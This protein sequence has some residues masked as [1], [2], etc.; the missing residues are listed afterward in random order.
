MDFKLKY[1]KN[2]KALQSKDLKVRSSN[3][4]AREIDTFCRLLRLANLNESFRWK[5][6]TFLDLGAGDQFLKP[7][8]TEL[9]A[10]YHP[11]DYDLA[12]FNKDELPY[13][14]NS[15]DLIFSLAVI[16]HI[17]NIDHFLGQVYRL[18]KPGGIFYLSTP[19]FKYCYKSFYNDP[20]HVRPFTEVSIYKVLSIFGFENI[21]T[22]PGLRSKSDWFYTNRFRFFISA[23]LL[24]KEEKWFLPSIFSGKA[25]SVIAICCKPIK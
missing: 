22:Y 15:I 18:L 4:A 21:S 23:N 10:K 3:F 13:T 14:S 12:D 24:T 6:K 2:R 16:E 11:I 25:T 9:G 1:F 17:Y 20:T 5:D 19:N 8:I 7:K